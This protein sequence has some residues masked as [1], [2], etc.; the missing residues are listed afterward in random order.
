[1][2]TRSVP[3]AASW[4]EE[5]E[6]RA[7]KKGQRD[8]Q[9]S[10]ANPTP[11]DTYEMSDSASKASVPDTRKPVIFSMNDIDA[12]AQVVSEDDD[13]PIDPEVAKRLRKKIDRHLLPLMM[14]EFD[15]MSEATHRLMSNCQT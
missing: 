9:L 12:A 7:H 13:E 2:Y 8:A 5:A 6:A 4:E 15:L 14:R 3:V 11:L 10:E 1:M